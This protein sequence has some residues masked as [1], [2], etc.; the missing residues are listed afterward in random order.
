M[1]GKSMFGRSLT[2][3][4][5]YAMMPKTRMPAISSVVITGRR[6]KRSVVIVLLRL[7]GLLRLPGRLALAGRLG[8]R[9]GRGGRG[10]LHVHP[11]ARHQA[12]V[13]V[14]DHALTRLHA[15]RDHHV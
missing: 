5:R 7:G 15:T 4:R 2:G 10:G 13:A 12:E 1:V 11:R 6:M 14:G 3:S 9:L 8:L